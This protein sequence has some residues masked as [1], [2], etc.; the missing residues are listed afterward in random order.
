MEIIKEGE[1]LQAAKEQLKVLATSKLSL[2]DLI[3]KAEKDQPGTVLSAVPEVEGG[4]NVCEV[5]VLSQG[6]VTE[7][8]YDVMT[9]EKAN[10]E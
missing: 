1:D 5:R 3:A 7:I 6:K 2:L 4:K 10:V 9:G 8:H